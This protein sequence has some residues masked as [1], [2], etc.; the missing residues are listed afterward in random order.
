MLTAISITWSFKLIGHID[1]LILFR[2]LPSVRRKDENIEFETKP[3]GYFKII[4]TSI[5]H[6]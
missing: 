4:V 5:Y 2:G 1:I 6:N 3:A